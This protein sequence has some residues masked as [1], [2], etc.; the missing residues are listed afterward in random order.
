ME[1]SEMIEKIDRYAETARRARE[2]ASEFAENSIDSV[3]TIGG[4]AL[5]GYAERKLKK[6]DGTPRDLFGVKLGQAAGAALTLTGLMGW[7][8]KQSRLVGSVGE[9]MLA[10]EAGRAVF[11]ASAKGGSAGVGARQLG[12]GG[13]VSARELQQQFANMANRAA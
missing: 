6:D 10:Y 13:A 1:R 12:G 9:G 8:G 5:A 3:A 11:N 2:K 7:A 4:G